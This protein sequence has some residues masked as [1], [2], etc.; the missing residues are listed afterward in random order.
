MN[1]CS[2]VDHS[3]IKVWDISHQDYGF[4]LYYFNAG[5]LSLETKHQKCEVWLKIVENVIWSPILLF[6][7]AYFGYLPSFM[8]GQNEKSPSLVFRQCISPAGPHKATFLVANLCLFLLHAVCY[9]QSHNKELRCLH[10][11]LIATK[12]R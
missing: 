4:F 8:V 12:I 9:I 3:Y 7:D 2:R 6:V 11:L 1:S 10:S 5:L